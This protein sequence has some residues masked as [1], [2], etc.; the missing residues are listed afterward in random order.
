MLVSTGP[1]TRTADLAAVDASWVWVPALIEIVA[2]RSVLS[3]RRLRREGG[4]VESIPVT[5]YVQVSDYGERRE[6]VR[7][8]KL[9]RQWMSEF[10][11]STAETVV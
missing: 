5:G 6:P 3:H 9:S 7:C 10:P 11:T 1:G 4:R 2:G 8:W